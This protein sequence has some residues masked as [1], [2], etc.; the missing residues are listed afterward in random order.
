MRC[1]ARFVV[2]VTTIARRT[3]SSGRHGR[4]GDACFLAPMG[5]VLR[6]AIASISLAFLLP[7][8]DVLL[9]QDKE[10]TYQSPAYSLTLGVREWITQGRS[11]HN[12]GSPTGPNVASELS[13]R[14]VNSV[15]TQVNGDLVV[16]RFILNLSVGHGGINNGDLLDEDWD[17]PNRTMRSSAT[18]S[19]VDDGSIWIV[20]VTP[21]VRLFEWSVPDNPIR[22]GYD[23]MAGYQFWREQY[24]AF[25]GRDIL[26]G[27]PPLPDTRSLKQTNTWQSMRIG[28][29]TIFPAFSFLAV[30]GSIFYIPFSSHRND[31]IH[32]LRTDLR[33]DPS[34]L[35][36]ATGGNGIQLE[37]SVMVRL[38]RG[39]TAEAGYAYWDIRSGS[40]TIQQNN[41]D[42]TIALGTHNEENTKRQGVFF[43][44]NWV[45]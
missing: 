21:G 36:T 32:D 35:S 41:A 29:R 34:F 24:V 28:M 6:A 25:G 44:V 19:R 3:H 43:A 23:L 5:R 17:G 26:T 27:N 31:D 22:G 33:K 39:L 45:F 38:W 10:V 40:G 20:S 11:S 2:F 13:W 18:I 7:L 37:G 9:A 8:P 15:I 16:K 30:K 14:G 1:I 12:I 42:G 4:G